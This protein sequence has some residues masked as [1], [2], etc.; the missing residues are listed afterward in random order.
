MRY[1]YKQL[2]FMR[3]Y[4]MKKPLIFFFSFIFLILAAQNVFS[5]ATDYASL[6]SEILSAAPN[7]AVNNIDISTPSLH[8]QGNLGLFPIKLSIFKALTLPEKRL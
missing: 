7:P 5:A 6:N 1:P 4:N 3:G 8:M 2:I